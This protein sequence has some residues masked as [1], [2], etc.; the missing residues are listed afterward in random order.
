MDATE[1]AGA[2]G[3]REHPKARSNL[4]G[5]PRRVES[6]SI[7]RADVHKIVEKLMQGAIDKLDGRMIDMAEQTVVDASKSCYMNQDKAFMKGA[8][9][10]S[11]NVLLVSIQ[12][13]L[14]NIR[15]SFEETIFQLATALKSLAISASAVARETVAIAL[16]ALYSAMV[17]QQETEKS[18][19]N[20]VLTTRSPP[21]SDLYASFDEALE[22]LMYRRSKKK[23][24]RRKVSGSNR[25]EGRSP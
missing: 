18:V 6:H 11:L 20:L 7:S 9:R 16:T 14:S 5:K 19:K 25:T 10:S 8:L 17:V 4:L 12:D 15:N 3:N 2:D 21:S 13:D 24:S 23:V 1:Q 22:C